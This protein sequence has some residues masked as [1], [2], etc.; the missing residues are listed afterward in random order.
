MYVLKSRVQES[1]AR[2]LLLIVLSCAAGSMITVSWVSRSWPAFLIS[3]VL[4]LFT[5]GVGLL[6]LVKS[7]YVQPYGW[8]KVPFLCGL[9][10]SV[11]GAVVSYHYGAMS[12]S[13]GLTRSIMAAGAIV[14]LAIGLIGTLQLWLVRRQNQL[15][16]RIKP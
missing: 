13:I 12:H 3:G 8:W 9:A 11:V 6:K 5:L 14:G 1:T 15:E 4:L 7:P 2:E 16:V 10:M